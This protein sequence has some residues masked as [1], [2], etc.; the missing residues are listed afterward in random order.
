MGAGASTSDASGPVASIVDGEASILARSS[1]LLERP[2]EVSRVERLLERVS[3]SVGGPAVLVAKSG[4]GKS[5]FVAQLVACL[6]TEKPR[7]YDIVH[8]VFVGS[9]AGSTSLFLVLTEL[10]LALQADLRL[11]LGDRQTVEGPPLPADLVSLGGLLARSLE[12]LADEHDQRVLLC[13]DAVNELSG[14]AAR[15]LA[16]L[17]HATRAAILLTTIAGGD[18]DDGAVIEVQTALQRRF[19]LAVGAAGCTSSSKLMDDDGGDD[20]HHRVEA[21]SDLSHDEQ[22]ALLQKLAAGGC[23]AATE[24][25]ALRGMADASSPLY[26]RLLAPRLARLAGGGAPPFPGTALGV[27]DELVATAAAA[28]PRAGAALAAVHCSHGGVF[29]SQLMDMIAPPAPPAPPA[30]AGEEEANSAKRPAPPSTVVA[31][32]SPAA[33]GGGKQRSGAAQKASGKGGGGSKAG[34]S[35]R[36]STKAAPALA[37]AP[38]PAPTPEPVPALPSSS[39]RLAAT[40][41]TLDFDLFRDLLRATPLHRGGSGET[42]PERVVG[43]VHMQARDAVERRLLGTEALRAAA[44]REAAA[45]FAARYEAL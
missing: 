19:G 22:L 5:T 12:E 11:L 28:H 41:A 35:G 9:T 17:P 32:A 16:W 18:G 37:P 14:E 39:P 40:A 24:A 45:Y 7:R 34:K 30:L 27:F 13:F 26:L 44:H 3:G 15:T 4:S 36:A 31:D 29:L 20:G 2:D 21:L 38:A 43:F 23:V 10:C 25:A 1:V 42:E 6:R 33:R 8:A